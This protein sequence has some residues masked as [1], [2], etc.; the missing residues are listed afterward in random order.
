MRS[1]DGSAATHEPRIAHRY[2]VLERLGRGGTAVVYRVRDE[3]RADDFALK[4][5]VLRGSSTDGEM[6]AQFE[7]EFSVLAQ[8]SHPSVI[9]VYDFGVAASGPYYTMELLDGGDLSSLAPM[10]P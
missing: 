1:N 9:E 4:Q 6:R 7:R 8:L 2:E 3:S 10:D 5:L